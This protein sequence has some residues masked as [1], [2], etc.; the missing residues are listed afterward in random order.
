[1]R[2]AGSPPALRSCWFWI[3]SSS[4]LR[5]PIPVIGASNVRQVCSE[6]LIACAWKA[7]GQQTS[8][9]SKLPPHRKRNGRHWGQI[10]FLLWR[11]IVSDPVRRSAGDN[12]LCRLVGR[13]LHCAHVQECG[14]ALD[15]LDNKRHRQFRPS[16]QYDHYAINPT[17]RAGLQNA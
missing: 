5:Q 17:S 13:R 1:M 4:P 7:P 8:F 3:G 15:Q 6:N 14:C 10:G 16:G 9:A 11:R 2:Q 12:V